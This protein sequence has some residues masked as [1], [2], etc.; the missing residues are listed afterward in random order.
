MWEISGNFDVVT[1]AIK[2]KCRAEHVHF[3]GMM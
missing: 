3:D 2:T 1:N